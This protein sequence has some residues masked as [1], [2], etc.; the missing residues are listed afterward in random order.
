MEKFTLHIIIEAG[1]NTYLIL[2]KAS[3]EYTI[4]VSTE[5]RQQKLGMNSTD[6]VIIYKLI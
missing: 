3:A 2:A 6:T 1:T 4:F 5:H